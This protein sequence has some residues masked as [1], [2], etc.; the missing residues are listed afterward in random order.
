MALLDTIAEIKLHNSAL[1]GG[2]KIESVKSYLDEAINR[3]I[4]PAIGYDQYTE[5]V[6]VKPLSPTDKQQRVIAL[7]QKSLTGFMIY[8]WADQ[9]AVMFSDSGINVVKGNN[10]L[11][12]SDKKI[13][14]LKKQN[15]FSGYNNLELAVSLLEDNLSDFP[16]YQV[17]NEHQANRSLLINTSSEFQSA[18]VNI[19]NDARLY[20]TLRIYQSDIEST[21]LEPVLGTAIKDALHTYI[22]NNALDDKYKAL[23]KRVQKAVAYHTIS[24]A[25]TYMAISLDANGIF[26]TG[27]VGGGATGNVENR[28]TATEKR[29]A[30]AMYS[31]NYK[32]EQQM[33]VIRKYLTTNFADFNYI[34]PEAV[35]IN[36]SSNNVHFL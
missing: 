24:E 2:M 18:G 29:L 13:L 1:G 27:E 34:T 22:L 12:A 19:N 7:L 26:E 33:E 3:H 20:A 5:L 8:Y 9:G 36:D 28:A 32:A 23:L 15:V 6:N 35:N 14:S 16:V 10:Y 30:A 17:S 4:I 21:Y 31:Y 11:P 25:I